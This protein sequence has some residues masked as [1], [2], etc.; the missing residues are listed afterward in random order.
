M[1]N[2]PVILLGGNDNALS[3]A[4]ALG[5]RSIP[6]FALNPANVDVVHSRHVKR[7]PTAPRADLAEAARD[8]FSGPDS[9]ELEGAVLLALSDDAI[10]YLSKHRAELSR[11]FMLD[12]SNPEA[13]LQMLDKYA[14][15]SAAQAAGVATP[16]FW[17]VDSVI[18]LQ[19]IRD[20]LVF[21]LIVK[22]VLSHVFQQQYGSKFIV[23][24]DYD[25]VADAVAAVESSGTEAMLVERVPGPDSML[26]SYYSYLDESGDPQFDF[27]KRIIRRN[28]PGMGLATYH[29]TDHVE[30]IREPSL[31]LCR[32][33]GLIGL[34]N[35]EFKLD[36][37]D[38]QLKLIECNAR[39]TG[40][41]PLV[42]RSGL[43]LA[44]Y[45]YNRIVGLPLPPTDEVRN[46]ITM[47]DPVRDFKAYRA[48]HE[49]GDL[50][51][52]GWL[53]SVSRTHAVHPSFSL[54]DPAPGLA[55]L[56]S[57]VRQPLARR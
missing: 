28:P 42:Q 24:E 26:C 21:P 38:D 15:Y 55:R 10:V 4:R 6:V 54:H 36:A 32:E 57:Y 8:F 30:N 3:V 34:V 11:R 19:S 29:V 37:R 20:E 22:P 14:T 31:Q 53:K 47:W 1:T 9:R 45:V 35:F 5:R 17:P 44:G 23:A 27:T 52:P 48:L 13:A 46:G 43:D 51:L 56:R 18:D 2:P 50:S 41:N 12:L 39:F 40:G 7:I 16:K 49:S 25:A 33:V